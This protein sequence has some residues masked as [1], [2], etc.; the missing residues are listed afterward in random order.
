MEASSGVFFILFRP[1]GVPLMRNPDALTGRPG[2]FFLSSPFP[3]FSPA[4]FF[5]CALGALRGDAVFF[6]ENVGTFLLC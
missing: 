1:Q 2:E 6:N 5:L 3:Q 4:A